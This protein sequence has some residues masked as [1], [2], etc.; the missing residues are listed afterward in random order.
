M[1]III[2][3]EESKSGGIKE[4]YEY[5]Y[6]AMVDNRDHLNNEQPEGFIKERVIGADIVLNQLLNYIRSKYEN[7]N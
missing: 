3:C 5:I 1:K 6:K 2:E 4:I 7:L